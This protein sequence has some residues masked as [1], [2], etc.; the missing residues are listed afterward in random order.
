VNTLLYYKEAKRR[1]DF[2]KR[3]ITEA[4][5]MASFIAA[6]SAYATQRHQ[7]DFRFFHLLLDVWLPAELP[8][9]SGARGRNMRT[10]RIP[11][12]RNFGNG[13]RF[14]A[15]GLQ[16]QEWEQSRGLALPVPNLK[17]YDPAYAYEIAVIIEDGI[18][19]N[20]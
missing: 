5:S 20:V 7:H 1:A 4:G 8:I 6:G 13:P 11:A 15:K 17:A 18:R 16:H 10:R 2:W 12:G 9:L 19:P 14:P 3:A